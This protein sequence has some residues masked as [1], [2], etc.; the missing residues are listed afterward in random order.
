[1]APGGRSPSNRFFAIA[2][3]PWVVVPLW[4]VA[5]W[6]WAI[7]ALFDYTA[8]HQFLHVIEHV[9]LF[10]TGLA[11]WW[12]II[13][14]L[15]R[16]RRRPN[17]QRLAL[18]GFTRLASAF[19]CV[20]LTWLAVTEYPLYADA[21]RAY[22]LSAIADQRLAG[23]SMCFVEIAVFGIAFVVVFLDMLSRSEARMA[24]LDAASTAGEPY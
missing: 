23:A 12:L 3:S 7:P 19:V 24:L 18:L 8:T 16:G 9:T 2:T 5:T 20:P 1:M 22:G 4:A 10:Y 21:P 13:E 14:P 15:P 11:L 17:G 6:V